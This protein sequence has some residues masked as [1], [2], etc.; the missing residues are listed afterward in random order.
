MV[1][2]EP[3]LFAEHPVGTIGEDLT[4]MTR[5]DLFSGKAISGNLTGMQLFPLSLAEMP[6][7]EW[8]RLHPDTTFFPIGP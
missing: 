5:W 2:G 3:I 6:L 4:T 7:S 1:L 8:S